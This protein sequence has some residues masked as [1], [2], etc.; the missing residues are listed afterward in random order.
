MQPAEK[1]RHLKRALYIF[2]VTF[3]VGAPSM[4]MWQWQSGWSCSPSQAQKSFG[5]TKKRLVRN[6]TW[7]SK[8]LQ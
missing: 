7:S 4:I 6:T 3:I 5:I 8:I 1:L 2:G